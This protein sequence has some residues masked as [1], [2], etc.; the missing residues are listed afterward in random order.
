[1]LKLPPALKIFTVR[2][3]VRTA[4]FIIPNLK[5]FRRFIDP[6]DSPLQKKL[7]TVG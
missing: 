2:V 3:A 4:R 1:M 6:V 7:F 5:A